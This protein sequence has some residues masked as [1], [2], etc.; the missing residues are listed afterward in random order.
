MSERVY[1]A[2]EAGGSKFVCAAGCGATKFIEG[3]HVSIPTSTPAVTLASVVAFFE[4]VRHEV[5][6]LAGI[7][8]AAFGPVD[9]NRRSPGWGR[10]LATPKA[11]WSSAS[12]IAPLERFDCAVAV[13]TDVNA[14]ALAEWELGAG[15]DTDPL[16]YVT[17]GT[18]IGGG[19]V[20]EG[21]TLRGLLHPEMGH[22]RVQR[23]P[24]DQTFEGICPFHG[25][26]LEGLASG[27]AIL[28]RW[29]APVDAWPADHPGLEII[30]GY[31]GQLV[32][33]IA[34]VISAE[35]ILLGGGAMNDGR[36]LPH[37]R[38]AAR[39]YL[40]GYLPIDARAGGFDRFITAPALGARA[41]IVGAMLLA[42]RVSR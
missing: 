39:H 23:D 10:L 11:G 35:R 25:D 41:G 34:L 30:G 27:P 21:R 20:I 24:R 22:I 12:L 32:A 31:L 29:N 36:L 9:I 4:R 33:S 15:S 13:D 6:P 28:K 14:A 19:V 40:N 38:A 2:I 42:G 26:C 7:G 8:I 16:V 3:L 37:V 5:G 17:V 18:G 1:G